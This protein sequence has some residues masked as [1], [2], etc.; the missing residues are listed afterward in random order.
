MRK[1]SARVLIQS[2]AIYAATPGQDRGGGYTPNYPATPTYPNVPC[3][4]QPQG[5]VET[6][7][8]GVLIQSREWRIMFG[9][10]RDVKLRDKIVFNGD[11]GTHTVYVLALRDEAGRGAAFS[12]KATERS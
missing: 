6:Y 9:G 4:A 7:D 5:F 11:D 1:P 12:V 8:Q 2:C 3:T 10:F